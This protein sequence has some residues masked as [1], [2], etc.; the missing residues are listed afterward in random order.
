MDQMDINEIGMKHKFEEELERFSKFQ[1]MFTDSDLKKKV[2]PVK[3]DLRDYAKYLLKEG[4]TIEKREL[5]S[6]LKSK[7]VM[8]KKIITLQK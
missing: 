2:K 5:L 8:I 3:M 6:C 4:N 7:L 1:K